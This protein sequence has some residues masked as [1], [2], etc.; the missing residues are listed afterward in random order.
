[1]TKIVSFRKRI[2]CRRIDAERVFV[3]KQRGRQKKDLENVKWWNK[4]WRSAAKK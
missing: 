4:E 2:Y 3:E 1:M